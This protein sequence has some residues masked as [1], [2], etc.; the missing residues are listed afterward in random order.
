MF[1]Y[2]ALG[3][4]DFSFP[5]QSV[6]S[7]TID[8]TPCKMAFIL[9]HKTAYKTWTRHDVHAKLFFIV[10]LFSLLDCLQNGINPSP[11][12]MTSLA[13]TCCLNV[14]KSFA[15]FVLLFL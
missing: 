9:L 6:L 5:V 11:F 14:V 2:H 4:R 7:K 10:L 13:T 3:S 12:K 1:M 8:K 15:F